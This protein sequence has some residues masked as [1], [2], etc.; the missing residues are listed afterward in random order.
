MSPID[1]KLGPILLVEDDKADQFLILKAFKEL[2][3]ESKDILI[4]NNGEDAY[5]YLESDSS[6]P[7]LILCD[8]NMPKV[9]GLELRERIATNPELMW[10]SIP[11]V[12]FSSSSRKED[13]IT[14]FKYTVQGYFEKPITFHELLKTLKVIFDYWKLSKHPNSKF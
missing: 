13:V 4:V 8:V 11:F 6:Q 5:K 2:G 12:F 14:A 1:S 9:N 10:K 3:F 7:F